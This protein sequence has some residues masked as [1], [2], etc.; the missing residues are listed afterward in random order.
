VQGRVKT[1]DTG[2][3]RTDYTTGAVPAQDVS[4][5]GCR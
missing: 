5:S 1:V 3:E 4:I 2:I